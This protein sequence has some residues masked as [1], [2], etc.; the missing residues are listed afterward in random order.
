MNYLELLESF[1]SEIIDKSKDVNKKDLSEELA[2]FDPDHFI[3]E[4]VKRLENLG[5][6]NSYVGNDSYSVIRRE[7]SCLIRISVPNVTGKSTIQIWINRDL[8]SCRKPHNM[9]AIIFYQ[10]SNSK[11]F[12]LDINYRP[13]E[14]LS[15]INYYLLTRP[16]IENF[17]WKLNR[18][19]L[20]VKGEVVSGIKP[21]HDK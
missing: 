7:N 19:R 13:K 5:Y 10:Q 21:P 6:K 11:G 3:D 12:N 17:F 1:T 8:E 20:I 4:I 16:V 2:S 18:L 14:V 9:C 15:D